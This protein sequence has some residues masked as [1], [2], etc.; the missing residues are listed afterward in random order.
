MRFYRDKLMRTPESPLSG[1]KHHS[2][3]D[4]LPLDEMIGQFINNN[5][6]PLT[7]TTNP[8]LEEKVWYLME[9]TC[10]RAF[11]AGDL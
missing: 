6:L 5:E 4:R 8:Q 2:Y 9:N 1:N 7:L 11:T 10:I 3:M